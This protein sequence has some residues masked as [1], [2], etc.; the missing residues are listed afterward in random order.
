VVVP[1]F[2][3]LWSLAVDLGVGDFGD[4]QRVRL[5]ILILPAKISV[6]VGHTGSKHDWNP[7]N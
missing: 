5:M 7:R 1:E 3:A 4:W 2:R 6:R